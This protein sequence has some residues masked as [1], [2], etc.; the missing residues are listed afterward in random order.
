[1]CH[2]T[3]YK[4]CPMS[5]S[6]I[7]VLDIKNMFYYFPLLLWQVTRYQSWPGQATA[8]MVG[9]LAIK[10]ARDNATT[11]LG[12]NFNIK[13]FHYQVNRWIIINYLLT[14]FRGGRLRPAPTLKMY[15]FKT[16]KATT[17]KLNKF[18]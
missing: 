4:Q 14:L 18:S 6:N 5:V 3:F 15:N 13:D 2:P 8:Y 16:I 17:T 7:V 11:A 10:N 1:M 12:K 9:R